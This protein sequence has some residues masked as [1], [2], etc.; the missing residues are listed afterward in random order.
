ML[1]GPEDCSVRCALLL[2]RVARNHP[3]CDVPVSV[4]DG[5]VP[6][7]RSVARRLVP[8]T[9]DH[10]SPSWLAQEFQATRQSFGVGMVNVPEES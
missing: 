7:S 4:V 8:G 2:V 6:N 9:R 1:N 3:V 5:Y 10:H